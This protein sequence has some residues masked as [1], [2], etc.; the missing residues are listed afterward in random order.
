MLRFGFFT[1]LEVLGCR[2]YMAAITNYKQAEEVNIEYQAVLV[3]SYNE[4]L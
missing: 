1:E 4:G 2:E 3:R